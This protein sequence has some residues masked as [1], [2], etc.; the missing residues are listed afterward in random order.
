MQGGHIVILMQVGGEVVELTVALHDPQFPVALAH[1]YL[2][3]LV[4]LPI[5]VVV[6]LLPGR[7][8]LKQRRE[9]QPVEIVDSLAGISVAL[10]IVAHADEVAERGHDVVERQLVVAPHAGLDMG[11]PAHDERDAYAALEAAPLEAP[12]QA[13]AIE[14]RGVGAALLVRP[15]V[16]GEDDDG[17]LV[18]PL[19]P[20]LLHELPDI[21]VEAR[22]HAG[23]LG[24]DARH[25]IVARALLAAPRLVA[26]E[27]P[28]VGLDD[29]VLRLRQFGVRQRIGEQREEGMGLV[30]PVEPCHGVSVDGVGGILAAA[31]VPGAE[32]GIA[33][34]LLHDH[35]SDGSVTG[36]AGIAVEKVGIVEMGLKLA[37]VAVVL[38]H[39]AFVGRGPRALVAA[40]P[41]A[42]HARAVAVV[43]H[44][45][46]QDDVRAVIGLLPH[47]GVVGVVPVPDRPGLG[48]VLPVAPDPC[49][50]RVLPRHQARPRGGADGT[51]RV[52]LREEHALGGQTIDVGR[53]DILLPVAGQVAIAHVIAK[54]KQDV[55][56]LMCRGS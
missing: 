21:G 28:A 19:L 11:G 43:L 9:G 27:A 5:E 30:L 38:V 53:A 51:A 17:V 10:H 29:R 14:E 47:H 25:G 4:K 12:Q 45:L 42:E 26:A 3:R 50:A 24:M 48:P 37:D 52:S 15:V 1:S 46:G 7:L 23:K 33:D 22:D 2:V 56:P 31:E 55:R 6:L 44:Y 32:H 36:G 8:A 54:D 20:E 39:A 18:E 16:R 40:G 13:V 41:F 49:V 34:I 35:P